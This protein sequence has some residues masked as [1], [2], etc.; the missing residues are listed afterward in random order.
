MS[1][2]T[3]STKIATRVRRPRQGSQKAEIPP[4]EPVERTLIWPFESVSLPMYSQVIAG[5]AQLA[6]AEKLLGSLR[7]NF[8]FSCALFAQDDG[9]TD[10][11]ENPHPIQ[12]RSNRTK[13]T[14]EISYAVL[15][16]FKH[17]SRSCSSLALIFC[18]RSLPTIGSLKCCLGWSIGLPRLLLFREKGVICLL[19]VP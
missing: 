5:R 16:F 10:C 2:V 17:E 11:K 12:Q 13:M 7:P 1:V 18:S 3:D 9:N 4:T 14:T 19:I 8:W 6:V 15:L